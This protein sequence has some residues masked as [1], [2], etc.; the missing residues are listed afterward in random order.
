VYTD[1]GSGLFLMQVII[2]AVLTAAYRFRR[3]LTGLSTARRRGRS[4]CR[5]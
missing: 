3:L 5:S 4:N 2:A 1:P